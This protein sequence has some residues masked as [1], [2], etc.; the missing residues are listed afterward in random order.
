LTAARMDAAPSWAGKVVK[1]SGIGLSGSLIG[2]ALN[3]LVLLLVT[4]LLTPEELGLFTLAQSVIAVSLIF[5]LLGVPKGLERF[6]PY[7]IASGERARVMHLLRS[8]LVVS[9]AAAVLVLLVLGFG[10][11]W[12]A[13]TVFES[14]ELEHVLRLML[15]ALPLLGWIEI[16]AASFV[17]L[18]ELRYRVIIQQ[19]ALPVIKMVLAVVALSLGLGLTG[20]IGAY[21]ISLAV[22]SVMAFFLFRAH[23]LPKFRVPEQKTSDLKGVLSYCW[24]LSINNF[25]V[26]FSANV[27][28]LLLGFFLTSSDV[29]VYR[30]F[31]YMV[32]IQSLIQMSFAQIY[33]PLAAGFVASGAGSDSDLLYK[34]VAKWMFVGGG[35]AALVIVLLGQ[36][37]IAVLFPE[38]YQVAT[39]ALVILALG[40]LAV[41]AC[42]PQAPALEA[43][44]NTKLS[45]LNALLMLSLNLGLGYLL[46]P[47]FGIVGAALASSI[48]VAST[49]V[50]GMLEMKLIHGLWP[51]GP[52]TLKAL[53]AVLAT[54]VP[55]WL[56]MTFL[57]SPGIWVLIAMVVM[58]PAAL[59]L[60]L[61]M[62]GALDETDYLVFNAVRHRLLRRR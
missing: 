13:G 36:D 27:S 17:G 58:I 14:P 54:A 23:F 15:F 9:G 42:G 24:P 62:L 1:E 35:V 22:A 5:V 48:A 43:F 60:G 26:V 6:I 38:S 53:G 49:A 37:I 45:M 39:Q 7:L 20:W 46:I 47:S 19:L 50:V 52:P 8:V 34:R 61:R 55:F 11:P 30:I 18:K 2:T 32:L 57:D 31:V 3:Y 41:A 51:F 40:R 59:F 33:K 29:G 10:A 44:G 21:V 12:L 16:V 28:F 25:V 4:R 56:A